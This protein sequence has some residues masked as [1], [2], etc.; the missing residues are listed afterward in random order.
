MA[1]GTLSGRAPSTSSIIEKGIVRWT[2]RLAELDAEPG[3]K[4][5]YL[6]V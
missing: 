3:V 4:A 5:Q 2:G 1:I 6:S